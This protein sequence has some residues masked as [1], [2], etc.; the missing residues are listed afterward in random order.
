MAIVKPGALLGLALA[1]CVLLACDVGSTLSALST[2]VSQTETAQAG[3]PPAWHLPYPTGTNIEIG[4]C[5]LHGD[6]FGSVKDDTSTTTY[7]FN[8]IPS[9]TPVTPTPC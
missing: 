2:A 8:T 5:R 9:S 7:Y 6:N 3:L 1:A 4:Y